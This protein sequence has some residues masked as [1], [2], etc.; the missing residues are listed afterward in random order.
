MRTG[1]NGSQRLKR[2]YG[3]GGKKKTLWEESIGA[4]SA[5]IE[6]KKNRKKILNTDKG[7][8]NST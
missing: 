8:T 2:K 1:E 3:N 4:Y 7:G 6:K 5:G